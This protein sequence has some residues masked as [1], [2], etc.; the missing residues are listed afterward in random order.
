MDRHERRWAPTHRSAVCPDFLSNSPDPLCNRGVGP[1]HGPHQGRASAPVCQEV[2]TWV[3]RFVRGRS[4][5]SSP[6]C[7]WWPGRGWRPARPERPPRAAP[8]PA[9]ATRSPTRRRRRRPGRTG[10]PPHLVVPSAWSRVPSPNPAS[11]TENEL[12]GD[13]CPTATFCVAVGYQYLAGSEQTLIETWDGS[14]WSITPSPNAPAPST[15][16]ELDGVS[17]ANPTFCVAVGYDNLTLVGTPLVMA[18]NGSTW[19]IVSTPPTG[20]THTYLNVVS[21]VS[22]TACTAAGY[23]DTGIGLHA[24]GRDLE[25]LGLVGC[26]H[27]EPDRQHRQRVRRRLVRDR[28]LLRGDRLPPSAAATIKPWSRRGRAAAGR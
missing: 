24:P 22:P 9:V 5:S 4:A 1:Y 21:C 14:T 11:S 28:G 18:W 17:C 27:G 12:Y 23:V 26:R 13:S 15:G 6:R 8:R 2:G 3:V 20:A 25:R 7:W 19:T 16:D 10:A